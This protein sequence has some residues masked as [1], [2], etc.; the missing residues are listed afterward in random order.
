MGKPSTEA[1]VEALL[2]RHGR[3]FADE[4]GIDVAKESPGE[5]FGLLCASILFSARISSDLALRAAQ[6]LREQ[7]WTSAEKM[8]GATWAD[9][10]KVLNEA[11]Y[12]RF[13]ERTSSMLG[14]TAQLLLDSYDGDL[15]R[16]REAA[17]RDPGRE[18]SL[19]KEVKGLGDVGVDIFFREAQAAWE[20]L[21][22]FVDKRARKTAGELGLP[23]DPGQLA[24]LVDRADFPRFVAGLVRASKDTDAV[25]RAAAGEDVDGGEGRSEG[26][27][28]GPAGA[29]LRKEASKAELYER[30]QA[31]DVPGRSGMDKDELAQAVAA[32]E[33]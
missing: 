14:D 4:I 16:L 26:G 28:R 25:R 6:A 1:V 22:P 12:A 29:A 33:G 19:L 32:R 9:R 17:G 20:E 8:A 2:E 23:Q 24:E 10:A 18:R 11:G 13:D 21:Y 7:G 5:L 30:A 27:Q 3:T 31:L 15:R